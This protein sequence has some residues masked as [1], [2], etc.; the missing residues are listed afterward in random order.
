MSQ[1]NVEIVRTVLAAWNR[2]EQERVLS[3]LDPEI[4]FDA[5]RRA[6]NPNTY[7]GMEGMR[8]ML[9]DRDEVWEEFRT[10]PGEFVDV[11]N[12]VVVIGDWV[13]KG[14]GSGVEVQ[15]PTAHVFTLHDGRIS[16]WELGYTE[17]RE[18]LQAAGLREQA[19]SQ[20]NVEIVR[21]GVDAYNRGDLDRVLEGWA[22][23]AVLDWS[24][25]RGLDAGVFRGHDE[26][27]AFWQRFLAAFDETRLE[28]DDPVEL[29]DGLLLVENVAY[30]RGRD[31][32]EVQARSAWLITIRDGETTSLTLYQTKQEALEAA[33]LRE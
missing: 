26:I 22:P 18:A 10:E 19:M 14:K 21:R 23:D 17:R 1:E 5:T 31:D 2:N 12:R 9:A 4:V 27:R 25:S 29:E 33:A 20:E 32:I 7:L 3:L 13:G 6:V 16:R 24:N 11:G 30:L 28:I 8:L 15:Q